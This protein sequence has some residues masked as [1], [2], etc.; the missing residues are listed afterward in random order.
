MTLARGEQ[1]VPADLPPAMLEDRP[2]AAVTDLLMPGED[3][4]RL[5]TLAEVERLY[6]ERVLEATGGNKTLA[7]KIL[8]LDRKTI[9]RKLGAT[10]QG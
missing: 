6:L 5:P 1:I 7:A 4:S 8:G 2:P 9:Y 10:E 3:V